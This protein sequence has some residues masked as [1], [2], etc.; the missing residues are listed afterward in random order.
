M[1]NCEEDSKTRLKCGLSKNF[2][3][4]ASQ[5]LILKHS[6]YYHVQEPLKFFDGKTIWSSRRRRRHHNRV[7]RSLVMHHPTR[8]AI[9]STS[10]SS[11][12]PESTRKMN[13]TSVLQ[14]SDDTSKISNRVEGQIGDR[15][16]KKF[17]K[18]LNRPSFLAKHPI[19]DAS[20][21][22]YKTYRHKLIEAILKNR[23][24]DSQ[25]P[26]DVV[27]N[28]LHLNSADSV[29][30]GRLN[31]RYD[32]SLFDFVEEY[33]DTAEAT[34]RRN[35]ER[36]HPMDHFLSKSARRPRTTEKETETIPD[37]SIEHRP[38]AREDDRNYFLENGNSN[39]A[40]FGMDNNGNPYVSHSLSRSISEDNV[41]TIARSDL[42]SKLSRREIPPRSHERDKAR[43]GDSVENN[44]CPRFADSDTR[45]ESSWL[46]KDRSASAGKASMPPKDYALSRAVTL[47]VRQKRRTESPRP[48][49][50]RWGD[51]KK[52]LGD[53]PTVAGFSSSNK[54]PAQAGKSN[55]LSAS[56]SEIVSLC[57]DSSNKRRGDKTS[58]RSRESSISPRSCASPRP[59]W[60]S[61]NLRGTSFNRK[62][63]NITKDP[64]K[65]TRP[66][67]STRE[68]GLSQKPV[69][70]SPQDRS[71]ES[72]ASRNPSSLRR[73][74]ASFPASREK[75]FIGTSIEKRREHLKTSPRCQRQDKLKDVG[76]A[77]RVESNKRERT[78]KTP[79]STGE[80]I[81]A[82][83]RDNVA[84]LLSGARTRVYPTSRV[85]VTSAPAPASITASRTRATMKPRLTSRR[86]EGTRKERENTSPGCSKSPS[87]VRDE[88]KRSTK[89]NCD[90]RRRLRSAENPSKG[91]SLSPKI[92]LSA[93]VL[94]PADD[95][96]KSVIPDGE[97]L[98]EQVITRIDPHGNVK[99]VGESA[100]TRLD[101][102][103]EAGKGIKPDNI[104]GVIRL[105]VSKIMQNP[106][107]DLLANNLSKS[108]KSGVS[109]SHPTGRD[110]NS[111]AKSGLNGAKLNSRSNNA[112]DKM[113]CDGSS[114]TKASS[115]LRESDIVDVETKTREQDIAGRV[116]S[117]EELQLPRRDSKMDLVMNSG[118]KRYIKIVKQTLENENDSNKEDVIS[119]ASLSLSDAILSGQKTS[120]SLE[121]TQELQNVLNKIENN[122]ELLHKQSFPDVQNIV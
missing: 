37:K 106:P 75:E 64:A 46:T 17:S 48:E 105:K 50:S 58:H 5:L 80:G 53:Y 47:P 102:N 101:S 55:F 57:S 79:D 11:L 121:E 21:L 62:Y 91:A 24:D 76:S 54:H 19:I 72:D 26:G 23:Y 33:Y 22:D 39:F 118:L 52:N 94:N 107:T 110:A 77:A 66:T 2:P 109:T 42:S 20:N 60:L 56:S 88:W 119:L 15:E 85:A 99:M 18:S 71:R 93:E 69:V 103:T 13:S 29:I 98:A 86:D 41:S 31:D 104:N 35:V 83:T 1:R 59:P 92:E 81:S 70:S 67:T 9:D 3:V 44:N 16:S 4:H 61:A 12:H 113:K 34:S 30:G 115:V 51:S 6:Y 90:G 36:P 96:D 49:T 27:L 8:I 108:D 74:A 28:S 32:H 14:S 84:S 38:R 7:A 68:S 116:N 73:R 117:E 63:C 40:Q 122:P 120:L 112:I 95:T 100:G 10:S 89:L 82:I 97:K 25:P 45:K 78:L 111:K 87:V 114:I 43:F 65:C